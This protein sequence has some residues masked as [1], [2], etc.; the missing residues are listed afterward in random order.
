MLDWLTDGQTD[1]EDLIVLQTAWPAEHSTR[2]PVAEDNKG[3][4]VL[5]RSSAPQLLEELRKT[6][7]ELVCHKSF[8]S[9]LRPSEGLF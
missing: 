1:R 2:V 6:E 4:R 5:P 8:T 3:P 7:G 9:G